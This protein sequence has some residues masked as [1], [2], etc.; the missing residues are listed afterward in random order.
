MFEVE[1]RVVTGHLQTPHTNN[2]DKRTNPKIR[3]E[4]GRSILCY[5]FRVAPLWVPR[6]RPEYPQ[7]DSCHTMSPPLSKQREGDCARFTEHTVSKEHEVKAQKLSSEEKRDIVVEAAEDKKANYIT[8][9]DLR[10]KTLIADFFVI[11][12]GTSNIHIRSIADGIMEVMEKR[13]IRQRN[14]EG[15][16]EA[17]WVLLDYG[18]VVAH[19]MSEGQRDYYKLEGLWGSSQPSPVPESQEVASAGENPSSN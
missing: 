8:A 10:G 1:S 19:I 2:G 9:L 13:G 17:S 6:Q 14:L 5:K 7:K 12:S 4:N 11:C 15:Y 16:S 18:D 3:E